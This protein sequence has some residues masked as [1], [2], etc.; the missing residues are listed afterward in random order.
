MVSFPFDEPHCNSLGA[1]GEGVSISPAVIK[2]TN[3][4]VCWIN[5]AWKLEIVKSLVL[6][7]VNSAQFCPLF[8]FLAMFW[9]YH[10]QKE[11]FQA[12]LS[13]YTHFKNQM[14]RYERRASLRRYDSSL[15][16]DPKG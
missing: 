9:K 8:L 12:L 13:D 4:K 15:Q 10:S 16:I 1:F 5:F 3:H 6:V 11:I 7:G 2:K 14:L